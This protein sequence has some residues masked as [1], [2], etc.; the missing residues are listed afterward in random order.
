MER[1]IRVG[2]RRREPS[3]MCDRIVNRETGY[4][5]LHFLRPP[6]PTPPKYGREISARRAQIGTFHQSTMTSGT[7]HRAKEAQNRRPSISTIHP[8]P[9]PS[10]QPLSA[11]LA[12]S[13]R[14]LKVPAPMPS[15]PRN[16]YPPRAR[17]SEGPESFSRSALRHPPGPVFSH[18]RCR[19][20]KAPIES[21]RSR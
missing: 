3:G 5:A 19:Q 1:E 7:R 13:G 21:R 8:N 4:T 6:R 2:R 16:I 15:F 14:S 9:D 20:P 17:G 18:R 12:I 10:A 11:W